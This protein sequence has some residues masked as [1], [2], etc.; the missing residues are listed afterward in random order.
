LEDDV[1]FAKSKEIE[2]QQNEGGNRKSVLIRKEKENMN[3]RKS[4][5]IK[6]K[7]KEKKKSKRQ[8]FKFIIKI[9]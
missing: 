7:E 3:K 5:L 9:L 4:I 6:E 1:L 8:K 2:T